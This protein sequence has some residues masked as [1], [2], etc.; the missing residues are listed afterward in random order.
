NTYIQCQTNKF[1]NN[2]INIDNQ[3]VETTMSAEQNYFSKTKNADGTL[4]KEPI[5]YPYAASI[6]GKVKVEPYFLDEAMTKLSIVLPPQDS[7]GTV[8]LKPTNTVTNK[9]GSET[10]EATVTIDN[11]TGDAKINDAVFKA[12]GNA[13]A[14]TDE[15]KKVDNLVFEV[16]SEKA[17]TEIKW[18]FP[19]EELKKNYE[20]PEG[21]QI[22]APS[23]SVKFDF[24]QLAPEQDEKLTAEEVLAK[25]SI[26][27]I[28][29][30]TKKLQPGKESILYQ[31][32][33]FSHSGPLPAPATITI[34]KNAALSRPGALDVLR[35]YW[36]NPAKGALEAMLDELDSDGD[37]DVAEYLPIKDNGDTISFVITHCSEYI[38]A[39]ESSQETAIIKPD[40]TAVF[41]I[42][43]IKTTKPIDE[44]KIS[45]DKEFVSNIKL[46]STVG[47]VLQGLNPANVLTAKKDGVALSA[48]DTI[49]TGTRIVYEVGAKPNQTERAHIT[50]VIYGDANGDG[51]VDVGDL[52][53]IQGRILSGTK[54]VDSK[55]ALDVAAN[56][57]DSAALTLDVGDLLRLRAHLLKANL[58]DQNL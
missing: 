25:N 35:I 5:N 56:I 45:T 18:S 34:K 52:I 6:K 17:E 2:E 10:K 22:K 51:A 54:T 50:A 57:I 36:F 46:G 27:E 41:D 28:I 11:P 53:I 14:S 44:L 48:T 12:A 26:K 38:V 40:T 29:E 7:S 21:E 30:E 39:A 9:D 24:D 37:K 33:S 13:S 55:N 31:S 47:D 42:T 49:G 19:A 15:T 58:I 20:K 1:I 23:L 43:A 8:D 3:N 4:L 32:I 16:K